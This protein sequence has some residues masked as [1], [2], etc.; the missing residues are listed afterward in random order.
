M[1]AWILASAGFLCVSVM[2]AL[3]LRRQHREIGRLEARVAAMQSLL[4]QAIHQFADAAPYRGE[5]VLE[6]IEGDDCAMANNLGRLNLLLDQLNGL[7]HGGRDAG[8]YKRRMSFGDEEWSIPYP[9]PVEF[10]S[11]DELRK[12]NQ[13]PPIND[14]DITATDWDTLFRRIQSD[15][16]D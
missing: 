3:Q 2:V 15:D 9:G 6:T 5:D 13:L 7:L 10:E 11:P 14:N 1:I 4:E 12:F 8:G 16:L